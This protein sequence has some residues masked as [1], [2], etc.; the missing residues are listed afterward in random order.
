MGMY[1]SIAIS[2]LN[3]SPN[4]QNGA[5]T[6]VASDYANSSDAVLVDAI[7]RNVSMLETQGHVRPGVLH[8]V[9]YI[10]GQDV[11]PLLAPLQAGEG[12]GGA[13][14]TTRRRRLF[15]FVFC[16]DLIFNRSEH[17]KLLKTCKACLEPEGGQVIVSYS[18]HGESSTRGVRRQEPTTW[19]ETPTK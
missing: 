7:Q 5:R 9:G 11:T 10:W 6:V 8:P 15:D 12:E 14:A 2:N 4:H 17:T 18:H 19:I 16:A 3:P 1:D 13:G